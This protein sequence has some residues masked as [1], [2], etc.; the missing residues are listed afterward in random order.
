[1]AKRTGKAPSRMELRRAAEA[2]E[3][4]EKTGAE[5]KAPKAVK[6][7]ATKKA[8]GTT[9]P[10]PRAKK[11]KKV[12]I[13]RLRLCWG[14]FDN[15]NQQVATFGYSEKSAAEAKLKELNEK[16]RGVYFLQPVKEPIVEAP[17]TS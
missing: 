12:E 14:V 11:T 7:R 13:I 2:A 8:D 16:G 1:M 6:K 5:T 9:T 3:K 4:K 15:S 10:K 17:A